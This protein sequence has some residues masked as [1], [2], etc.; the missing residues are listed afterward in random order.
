MG[1]FSNAVVDTPAGFDEKRLKKVLKVV[2]KVIIP[3]QPSVFDIF[4]TQHFIQTLLDMK[5]SKSL[6]I[7]I[8]GMRVDE[9][10]ISA[11]KLAEFLGSL[12]IEHIGNVRSTQY[13]VHMAAH[14]LSLFDMTPSK[15][16]K[17]LKQW[18]PICQWLMK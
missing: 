12:P 18:G 8:I 16:E 17:D 3:I 7:A 1:K 14:G 13:Y 2:D 6:D 11:A 9:R 4:A 5:Q 15:I 10:T